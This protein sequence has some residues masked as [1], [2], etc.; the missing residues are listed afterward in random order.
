MF[1][2]LNKKAQ[3]TAEYVIV[4]GLIV[5]AVL[6]MQTYV[7]KGLQGR[8]KDATDYVGSEGQGVFVT[9]QY[10]PYYLKSSFQDESSTTSSESGEEGDVLSRDTTETRTR[11]GTHVVGA[12]QE[13]IAK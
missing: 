11:T 6:A 9:K 10:D 3:S 1:I 2:Y 13:Q 5:A 4:L 7:K 12:A 8:M